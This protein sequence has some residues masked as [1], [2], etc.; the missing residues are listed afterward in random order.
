MYAI[1]RKAFGKTLVQHQLVRFK[2]A[3]MARQIEALQDN[4][5]RV[6]YNFQCGVEDW[7]MG[8]QVSVSVLI[9]QMFHTHIRLMACITHTHT[10]NHSHSVR[11]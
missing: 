5:D 4:I 7:K 3:E 8:G 6:A 9:L 2:L 11:C 1:V 10:H